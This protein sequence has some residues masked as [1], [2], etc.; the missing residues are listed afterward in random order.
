M[1]AAAAI[2]SPLTT[3]NEATSGYFKDLKKDSVPVVVEMTEARLARSQRVETGHRPKV[4][5]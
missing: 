5:V 4:G 3:F 2:P 1:T